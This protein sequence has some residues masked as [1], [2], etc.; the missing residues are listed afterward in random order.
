MPTK[1]I[2]INTLLDKYFPYKAP[3]HNFF[4][5]DVFSISLYTLSV[6][7]KNCISDKNNTESRHFTTSK[8][9]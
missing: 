5:E 7:I 9:Y 1:Q 3:K 8:M 6:I 2:S 4:G